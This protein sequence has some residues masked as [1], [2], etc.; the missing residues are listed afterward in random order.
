[1]KIEQEGDLL[2]QPVKQETD[3]T[4]D[5]LKVPEGIHV[6]QNQQP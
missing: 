5:Y 2:S 6:T 3:L 1:M 4:M